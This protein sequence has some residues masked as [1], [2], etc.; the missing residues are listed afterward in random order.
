LEHTRKFSFS[1]Y[2]GHQQAR[3]DYWHIDYGVLFKF[4]DPSPVF[5]VNL[6]ELIGDPI[7]PLAVAPGSLFCTDTVDT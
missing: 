5:N 2:A 3:G 7:C 1:V 4:I 6:V